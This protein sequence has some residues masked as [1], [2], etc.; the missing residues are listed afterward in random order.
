MFNDGYEDD[1]TPMEIPEFKEIQLTTGE[2]IA[3]E[4][5]YYPMLTEWDWQF[6][7]TTKQ[8]VRVEE[9]R[10]VP[11][12]EEQL[13]I[14]FRQRK[15]EYEGMPALDRSAIRALFA[16]HPTYKTLAQYTQAQ[17]EYVQ[18]EGGYHLPPAIFLLGDAL[19]DVLLLYY[20][21]QQSDTEW[22]FEPDET[23]I[24][25]GRL[26]RDKKQ[27]FTPATLGQ[28][29]AAT[30]TGDWVK[31]AEEPTGLAPESYAKLIQRNILDLWRRMVKEENYDAVNPRKVERILR[32]GDKSAFITA[33]YVRAL[34]SHYPLQ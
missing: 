30:L 27:E 4:A 7:E 20:E 33:R 5:R 29:M 31:S 17:R 16:H 3:V 18:Y 13:R 21:W 11:M 6:D 25:P 22:Y 1:E 23:G 19:S 2:I 15:R 26:V 14:H 34:I 28:W 12:F 10:K 32:E 8:V 24:T 9:G